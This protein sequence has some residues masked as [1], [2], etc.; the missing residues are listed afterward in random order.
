[1]S[2]RTGHTN[3]VFINISSLLLPLFTSLYF[4]ASFSSHKN[5]AVM[6]CLI[7]VHMCSVKYIVT[8]VDSRA[9]CLLRIVLEMFALFYNYLDFRIKRQ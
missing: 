3:T 5:A 2:E 4:T 1:M 6:M 7:Y 8:P 9:N